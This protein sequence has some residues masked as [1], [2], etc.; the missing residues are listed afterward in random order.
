VRVDI[1]FMDAPPVPSRDAVDVCFV[2]DRDGGVG[3]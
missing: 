1:C 3:F 2:P